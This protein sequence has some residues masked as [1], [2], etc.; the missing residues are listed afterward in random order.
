MACHQ[1]ATQIDDAA[2]PPERHVEISRN[3]AV[4]EI[5]LVFSAA[6]LAVLEVIRVQKTVVEAGLMST[7][8]DGSR[9]AGQTHKFARRAPLRLHAA[10]TRGASERCVGAGAAAP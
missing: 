6:G 2:S 8:H 9:A 7:R 10:R 4:L 5:I 1:C 3:L